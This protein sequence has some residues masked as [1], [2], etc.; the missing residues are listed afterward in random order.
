M[1]LI[2]NRIHGLLFPQ[3]SNK[4]FAQVYIGEE[5]YPDPYAFLIKDTRRS[6][7]LRVNGI[8]NAE[9]AIQDNL[10]LFI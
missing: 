2:A 10:D 3:A 6:E 5:L 8:E 4:M 1:Y 9:I 7:G